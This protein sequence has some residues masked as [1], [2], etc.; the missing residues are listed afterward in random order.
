M[1]D[2]LENGSFLFFFFFSTESEFSCHFSALADTAYTGISSSVL[3]YYR[4]RECVS[5]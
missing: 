4:S 1:L 2:G 3:L 5:A